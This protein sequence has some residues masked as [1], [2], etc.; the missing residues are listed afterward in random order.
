MAQVSPRPKG[1]TAVVVLIIVTAVFEIVSAVLQ[2]LVRDDT[3]IALWSG[4]IT[5]VIAVVYLLLAKGIADGRNVARVIVAVASSL[6]VV[7]AVWI[8]FTQPHL[9]L[10]LIVQVILGMLVLGMLYTDRATEF[11]T[12]KAE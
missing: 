8:T 1:V 11:F 2:I 3:T 12:R 9:W 5:L 7:A 6:M 4:A 10:S